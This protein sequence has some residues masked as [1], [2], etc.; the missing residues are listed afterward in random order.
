METAIRA[1]IITREPTVGEINHERANL[2][3]AGP[4]GLSKLLAGR[5]PAKQVP[6]ETLTTDQA[7]ELLNNAIRIRL[8]S[9]PY[10]L[11]RC[12][13]QFR[14]KAGGT[15]AGINF[16]QF[17]EALNKYGLP[18]PEHVSREIFDRMDENG[19]GMLAAP[20]LFPRFR[21]DDGGLPIDLF[22]HSHVAPQFS[23]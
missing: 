11:I 8:Q 17:K 4:S 19:N 18:V 5:L 13:S 22:S 9:G 20:F 7:L 15:Y 10:G 2:A 1:P 3:L 12:W 16:E 21:R 14:E 23:S 6:L